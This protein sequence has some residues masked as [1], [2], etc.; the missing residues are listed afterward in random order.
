MLRSL[1]NVVDCLDLTFHHITEHLVVREVVSD[2]GCR[3]VSTVS[4]TECIVDVAVS[5]RSE[6]LHEL[7]LVLLYNCL[8]SLLLPSVA[9]SPLGFPSSSA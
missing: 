2:E 8:C 7:L 6:L 4:C 5:V 9:N 3:S 1:E